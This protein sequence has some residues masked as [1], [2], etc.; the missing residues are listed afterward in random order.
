[1]CWAVEKK[2]VA[3]NDF[4]ELAVNFIDVAAQADKFKK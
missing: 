4:Q 2:A 3:M 1:M